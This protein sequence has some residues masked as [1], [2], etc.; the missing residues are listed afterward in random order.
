MG[1]R[2]KK[3][4]K[5]GKHCAQETSD[6]PMFCPLH[7]RKALNGRTA[8]DCLILRQYIKHND[9]TFIDLSNLTLTNFALTVFFAIKEDLYFFRSKFIDCDANNLVINNGHF[10]YATFNG[11]RFDGAI[12]QGDTCDFEAATFEGDNTPFIN[13]T[14]NTKHTNFKYL[15]MLMRHSFFDYCR[16]QSTTVTFEDCL[17]ESDRFLIG[18]VSDDSNTVVQRNY[19]LISSEQIDFTDLKYYGI[20]SYKNFHRAEN[21]QPEVRFRRVDFSN[22]R[23]AN[24]VRANLSRAIFIEAVL[25]DVKFLN[26]VW[27]DKKDNNRTIFDD[28]SVPD[29]DPNKDWKEL[30][31][32]FTQLKKNYQDR[33]D[34]ARADQWF[35]RELEC[36]RRM[37]K[38]YA[39]QTIISKFTI[40][41]ARLVYWLYKLASNYGDS[42]IRPLS[43]LIIVIFISAFLY[44]MN[45]FKIGGQSIDYNWCPE[46]GLSTEHI[47]DFLKAILFS[48]A[49]MLLQ[50]GRSIEVVGLGSAIVHIFQLLITAIL[51]P[52]FLLALRRKFRR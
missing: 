10:K 1:N 45:G 15:K 48:M 12:F 8:D 9:R 41:V 21:K 43:W 52:L 14:F 49:A 20:F 38:E 22:M 17:I 30:R 46:C 29:K 25:E 51:A 47:L 13:C 3:K 18:I 37:I 42:Y 5:D 33:L 36:R 32:I 27:P 11:M 16:M 35:C 44:L 26:V 7:L 40:G 23:S 24:F 34:Y 31:N 2:C 28:L 19:L 4:L 39:G 6:H 50:V